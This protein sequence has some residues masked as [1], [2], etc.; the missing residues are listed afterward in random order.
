MV[1]EPVDHRRRGDLVTEDL[2]PG[3]EGLVR[4]DDQRGPLVAGTDE[5]EHQ[6]RRLGVEGDVADLV[7]DQQ[8]DPAEAEQLLLEVALTLGIAE[9]GDPFGSGR[10]GNSLAGQ[11]SPDP[12]RDRQVRLAGPRRVGVELL[13]LWTRCRT[14][15]G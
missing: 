11:A 3:A 14:V 15:F 12:D 8:G 13:T 6:V 10:E 7:D 5:A 9:P 4:G 1:N 2:P